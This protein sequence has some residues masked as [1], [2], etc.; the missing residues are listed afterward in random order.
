MYIHICMYMHIYI[1]I[2]SSSCV[3]VPCQSSRGARG[4]GQATL[5]ANSFHFLP[6][7]R[8]SS[9]VRRAK[10][11][12]LGGPLRNSAPGKSCLGESWLMK[13]WR[14]WVSSMYVLKLYIYIYICTHYTYIYIYKQI[15]IYNDVQSYYIMSEVP[16]HDEELPRP[17]RRAPRR[18]HKPADPNDTDTDHIYI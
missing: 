13:V 2:Y 11:L 5:S 6:S 17:L 9:S 15:T 18:Q 10:F 1:Y 3:G 7:P 14:G 16:L 12:K 8:P 4:N